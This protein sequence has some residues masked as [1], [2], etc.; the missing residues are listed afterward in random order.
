[1]TSSEGHGTLTI[2]KNSVMVTVLRP[3]SACA[4]RGPFGLSVCVCVCAAD[5]AQS[6]NETLD[7]TSSI[8]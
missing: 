1:M 8:L 6:G 2:A 4:A 5:G 7:S 3:S